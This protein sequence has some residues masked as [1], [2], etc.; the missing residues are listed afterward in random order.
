MIRTS[1]PPSL[2]QSKPKHKQKEVH[3]AHNRVKKLSGLRWDE[4]RERQILLDF[5]RSVGRDPSPTPSARNGTGQRSKW[6]K[7]RLSQLNND[8]QPGAQQ[9]T[10]EAPA[11]TGTNDAAGDVPDHA[12]P[13]A[14]GMTLTSNED[15]DVATAALLFNRHDPD[16]PYCQVA[17]QQLVDQI[18]SDDHYDAAVAM[19]T[20]RMTEKLIGYGLNASKTDV[21]TA[22][23]MES[24][25]HAKASR[26]GRGL[27]D[28]RTLHAFL[29]DVKAGV[30]DPQVGDTLRKWQRDLEMQMNGVEYAEQ[31][32]PPPQQL[33][34][35]ESIRSSSRS[36][37]ETCH[38]A[39]VQQDAGI[40]N[41]FDD[42]DAGGDADVEPDS[43][44]DD[45]DPF[46]FDSRPH[47]DGETAYSQDDAA[48]MFNMSGGL[49]DRSSPEPEPEPEPQSQPSMSR[50][51]AMPDLSLPVRQKLPEVT[52]SPPTP[53]ED[54]MQDE[55]Q[56]DE[57]RLEP[58][59]ASS[60]RINPADRDPRSQQRRIS[61]F[62]K[63]F[64]GPL[65]VFI[66][67]AHQILGKK[68]TPK[69][70]N[71]DITA[72]AEAIWSHLGEAK[73]QEWNRICVQL[74][75]GDSGPLNSH[76]GAHLLE[77]Q[78]LLDQLTSP[79]EKIG[80]A[81]K[82]LEPEVKVDIQS[83]RSVTE[84]PVEDESV[85]VFDYSQPIVRGPARGRSGTSQASTSSS[86]SS[87]G[88]P[89]GKSKSKK[90]HHS[91][92]PSGA[93]AKRQR[94]IPPASSKPITIRCDDESLN[95]N[96][97]AF[98]IGAP[99]SPLP[100]IEPADFVLLC[101]ST[102]GDALDPGRCGNLSRYVWSAQFKDPAMAKG[103]LEDGTALLHKSTLLPGEHFPQATKLLEC[104]LAFNSVTQGELAYAVA[105]AFPRDPCNLFR[106]R[107]D[108]FVLVFST[109]SGC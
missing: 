58:G 21:V 88:R 3:P 81:A 61:Q 109:P 34:S 86:K 93:P 28:E 99:D 44:V 11:D 13:P 59:F 37:N 92:P 85:Q 26:L 41:F 55:V 104:S 24:A 12:T 65:Q 80:P 36:A 8:A 83:R 5:S 2:E 9:D 19:R 46:V 43:D 42:A 16:H 89:W 15:Q 98:I 7:H 94:P 95:A 18:F 106:L 73:R 78:G 49:G 100:Q 90:R 17:V 70:S 79:P 76:F 74:Q 101:Q 66:F 39:D 63:R 30:L 57:G 53:R 47:D 14:I 97:I 38:P 48:D 72:R 27:V 87:K 96:R 35:P 102:Y 84:P 107:N 32:E 4:P 52:V 69:R 50:H 108:R 33:A 68:C 77:R 62:S 6:T 91:Q 10:E 105:A 75:S 29:T 22:D 25:R 51:T 31:P 103:L 20:A 40:A 1:L 56:H 71:A 82:S 67:H 45:A 60:S 23:L 64:P 54:P